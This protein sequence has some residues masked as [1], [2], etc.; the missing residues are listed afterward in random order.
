MQRMT[1]NTASEYVQERLDSFCEVVAGVVHQRIERVPER[2]LAEEL[3][4][5]TAHPPEDVNLLAATGADVCNETITKLEG[6]KNPGISLQV[7]GNI[8]QCECPSA[9]LVSRFVEDRGETAKI[10]D[11]EDRREHLAL[12]PVLRSLRRE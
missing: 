5:G 6:D 12:L 8:R 1:R 10:G 9:N 11:R 4:R 3:E 2:S 7:G